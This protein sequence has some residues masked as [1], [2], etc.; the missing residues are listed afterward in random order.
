MKQKR[1][2]VVLSSVLA[3][4]LL[5]PYAMG[6][7]TLAA[8]PQSQLKDHWN[9]DSLTSDAGDRTTGT[10]E[11]SGVSVVDS[12]NP[13]FGN[14]LRFG[15][16]TDNYFKLADYINTGKG[17]VSFS[18]WYR[19]DTGITGDQSSASAVLL[20]H[21]GAGRSLL[22]LRSSGQYHTYINGQD[23]LSKASVAKGGWQHIT[24]TF[25]Q[26]TKKVKF[27]I[28]GAL[29]SEQALGNST[30]DQL[31]TLRLGAHK[32]AGT[33]DPHPMRGDVDEFYVYE[34]VL[35]DDEA[36]ALYEDK[37]VELYRVEL[38]E[39]V[40]E[41]Q[42][43]YDSHALPE[44]H[45][46]AVAL[47]KAI[48]AVAGAATLDQMKQAYQDLED[49]VSDYRS[50][51]PLQLTVNVDQVDRTID[52]DSIF[53][54]NHRYAFNGYGTFDSETM[55]MKEEFTQ[56][57]KQAGFGSIRYPGGT[58]SNL[59]NWKT[60]LGPKEERKDQIHGFYNNPGQ[61]GITPNFGI[62]EIAD[63]AS[64]VDSEIVYVYSLGRGNAQDAADLVE[65]L[66][67]EVGTNPNG[68]IDWAQ[69]RADNGHPEPYHVRYFEIGNEMQQAYGQ[70][71]DGTSSQ[72]YWTD[73]VSGGAEKA[74]TEG[75]T[76][77]FTQRYAVKE[78]DWNKVASQSDGTAN[79]VRFL[80]YAN[81]NPGMM[82]EDGTIV[83][84]PSFQAVNDGVRVYVG[85]DGN[86]T[87]WTVVDSLDNS[88][89]NDTHCVVNYANGSIQFGDGVHG[90]I[91]AKGQNVYATYTVDREGFIDV[92]KAI[93]ETT[94][95]IN[96]AEG[97]DYQANVYTSFESQGFI[98][99]MNNLGANEWY[100]GMTIHPYSGTV[101]GGS[102]VNTFYD[103]AMKKAEDVGV[104]HVQ[105]YVNM[106][107]EGKVPVI[108]EFGIFRNT[109]SQVRSQ[110]HAL[111]IAKVMM[112]YVKL[113]SPYIQKHCLADWYSSGADSL[114][115]T[116]QAVIQVVAQD[117]ANTATGEGEFKFFSTPSAHVFQMLNASFGDQVVD[118]QV[119]SAPTLD[120]GVTAVT[121]L[122]SKDGDGNVYIAAVNV[123]R[124]K[125]YTVQ[126]N[127]PGVDLTGRTLEIQTLAS[128]GIAD[129]N[130]LENPDNV[131]VKTTQVV[132]DEN[133]V[134][135]LP[136][137]SFVVMKVVAP[138][139][140]AYGITV[141]TQGQGTASA[142]VE[143]ATAGTSVTL[144]AQAA[145]GW[146]FAGWQSEDVTVTDNTF[147]MPEKAVTVTAVF[148]QDSQPAGVDTS[149]LEK[150]VAYADTLT[151]DGVTDTAKAVFQKALAQAKAVL[152]DPNATQEQ[153]NEAWSNLLEGIWSL[154]LTQGDKT[155]L[156]QLI[157][158][159]E[160]MLPHQNKY[161]EEH[162]QALVD[163]LEAAKDVMASGDAMDVDVQPAAQALLDAILAQRFKADK[164]ILEALMGQAESMDL[165][166]YT[167]A[168][169]AVF[170]SALARAQAVMADNSL[171]QDDQKTVDDAVSAL[172]AAMEGL[173]AET[174]PQ[175]SQ[176]PE[177]TDKP[178][179]STK[180]ETTQ[181]PAGTAQPEDTQKPE[182]VPQTG[183]TAQVMGY[184]AALAS[185]MCLLAGAAV[186]VRKRRD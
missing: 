153:V 160:S 83:D 37:A 112:E 24:V 17:Q 75:G 148:E 47:A 159:A 5:M 26:D 58:I 46:Y 125:D 171:T 56:L 21:E 123:D 166:G 146:H 42:D 89:A 126:L 2:K 86:L 9:F 34:K 147:V 136:K 57:Y 117:G 156:E 80:R 66:N 116:Q 114:G 98:N 40:K 113:G 62:G 128:Q 143:T 36:Q 127:I 92:S 64:Q 157:E 176:S 97:T 152:A 88:G 20:Q 32:N 79:Q 30:V 10:M 28:N 91:P 109:E 50:A 23:V 7:R 142:S 158:K 186:A 55:Q 129:E 93:K 155:T 167:Q 138:K 151:T 48:Q 174:A 71:A 137:H 163:A 78:E 90:K 18:M 181:K 185:A 183:D 124:E 154:G 6:V 108:S 130:T 103:N 25:D 173:T 60:T 161:V 85:T 95:Q 121:T 122:A 140:E 164:S 44:D 3:C 12:G 120:N 27:Y 180:P 53:G 15:A 133:H 101:G 182:A 99:R 19:Y 100:D 70:G 170:R 77:T 51:I 149:L 165:T 87:E 14:V 33:T 35:T 150:T 65:Y 74:Y 177:T 179:A 52:A 11:G 54:I 172:T 43:L 45:A 29:D 73:Y 175:P 104:K 132:L 139:A 84:D 41:A 31:L 49:A 118:A 59:F 135:C 111:Y 162:W 38:Q 8:V 22:T 168:S 94:R 1:W 102:D 178:E 107:P 81:L 67:A 16:G 39:A 141:K 96:E 63:F 69:V 76:A 61:G 72:G 115:P 13:V 131:T 82:G 68:G 144:T 4:S 134:V 110:T 169:V 184:V 106:L 145:Q 105:D 119:A